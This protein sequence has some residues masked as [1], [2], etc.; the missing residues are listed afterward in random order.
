MNPGPPATPPGRTYRGAD[1][2][3]RQDERRAR[4]IEAAIET[5]GTVGYR[6]ATVDRVCAAAGLTKRYFYESFDDSESLLLAVYARV[7][8]ELHARIVA[9]A[10]AAAPD[11]EAQV[12]AALTALFRTI[13]DD[14]RV[15]RIAFV[16]ILAV[17]ATIDSAWQAVNT[18]FVDT[19]LQLT[20]PY[21]D[22]A[23][24]SETDLEILATGVLGAVVLIAQ[25]WVL[26]ERAQPIEALVSNAHTIV[27]AVLD[28]FAATPS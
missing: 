27:M 3:Q 7:A 23:G 17:S 2:R 4:L 16:E 12:R 11:V 19:I 5:F 14:P 10:E 1:P 22:T 20:K 15:A 13:D 8:E 9:D 28:R 21:L 26:G 24:L 25:R 18:A 6:N